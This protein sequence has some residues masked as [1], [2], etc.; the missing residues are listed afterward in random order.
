VTQSWRRLAWVATGA[1]TAAIVACGVELAG[2]SVARA[3]LVAVA[4]GTAPSPLTIVAVALVCAAL[5]AAALSRLDQRS[6]DRI[7]AVVLL[8]AFSAGMA[9]Q[10]RLGARLQSDGFYYFAHLRS[11]WFDGDQ[12]L[13]NDYR[14]LG[15]GDKTHLFQPTPT[16]Y[17]QSA[18][19]IGPSFVWAPFFALGD[20]V[21]NSLRARGQDVAVDG[22]SFPYRQ[23]ICVAG[24]TWGLIGLYFCYRLAALVIPPGWSALGMVL[25][26]G[27]SFLLWY[28]VKEPTMTHAPSMA[29]MAIFTWAWAM[30]RGHRA[31]WQWAVLGLI[32]GFMGT[33]RWQN[34][35]FAILPAIEWTLDAVTAW[36]ARDR[37]RLVAHCL[38]GVSF[39]AMAVIGFLPQMLVWKAIYG[40]FFAVSPIGPQIR[41]L[42]P[43]LVD[44][45]WSSQNGL[46]ATSPVL[47]LGIAGL[48]L[49]WR[50]DRRLATGA[51]AALAAMTWFNASVQD[52]WGSAAF[53]MRRFDGTLPLFVL[54]VAVAL[55]SASRFVRRHP[56][57]IVIALGSVLVVWNVTFMAAAL[58]GVVRIG[59]P[60]DFQN[61]AG[62]QASTMEKAVGHPFSWPASLPFTVGNGVSPS[63]YDRLWSFRFLSDPDRPYGR[64]D[65]G[66]DD[67]RW[68]GE[69]WQQPERRAETTF[70]WAGDSAQMPIALDHAAPLRVQVRALA[71]TWTGAP[72]QTLALEVNGRLQSAVPVPGDWTV[73]EYHVDAAQWRTG[74]NQVVLRFAHAARPRDVGAGGDD[75]LLAAAVDYVRVAVEEP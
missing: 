39:T 42:H 27:G 55:E 74:I 70:R 69:G 14:L 11:L 36:R 67:E 38:D 13:T 50:R 26:A 66:A 15:M 16:G 32:A 22:T 4:T 7:V 17:A 9:M 63:A 29:A 44:I 56:A 57:P 1:L 72:A 43:H 21:A 8:A 19:T 71:F 23:A 64:V 73:L 62:Y 48:V 25:V 30:T 5:A 10:L 52:W 2:R 41:L 46:L 68:L 40:R 37:H 47:Y 49:L 45:L 33:I 59:E 12:N 20:R 60:V 54:G 28:L 31:R 58:D 35:L 34:V 3:S 6:A 65:I 61:L 51:L 24:L 53:G 18:W 75:R